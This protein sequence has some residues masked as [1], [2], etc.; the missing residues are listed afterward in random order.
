MQP[1]DLRCESGEFRRSDFALVRP[2]H[3]PALGRDGCGC[4]HNINGFCPLK[5]HPRQQHGACGS[6]IIRADLQVRKQDDKLAAPGYATAEETLPGGLLSRAG[7][8]ALTD[9]AVHDAV[10]LGLIET[11]AIVDSV[12]F[13][14]R[15]Q[16]STGEGSP[17]SA[18]TEEPVA[19][20]C[21]DFERQ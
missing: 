1:G 2:D 18:P 9:H 21:S 19:R 6:L 11:L 17:A 20:D 4:F 10:L 13:N 14:R 15:E 16:T 12:S 8:A 3:A 5:G 7:C